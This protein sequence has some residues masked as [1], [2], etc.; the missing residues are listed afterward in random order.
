MTLKIRFYPDS[1]ESSRLTWAQSDDISGTASDLGC[2]DNWLP[3]FACI[4][5]IGTVY[6]T[7]ICPGYFHMIGFSHI[8]SFCYPV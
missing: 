3:H 1:R 5:R 2:D 7:Q 6:H 4:K 8:F